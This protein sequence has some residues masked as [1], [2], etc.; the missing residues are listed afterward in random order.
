MDLLKKVSDAAGSAADSV[1]GSLGLN[2]LDESKVAAALTEALQVATDKAVALVSTPDG[3]LSNKR[4]RVPVPKEIEPVHSALSKLPGFD[5]V[6]EEFE[7]ALNRAAEVASKE[8]KDIFAPV[9]A[10]LSFEKAFEILN[11]ASHAATEFFEACT[12]KVL[13]GKFLPVVTE[14]MHDV[15]LVAVWE[16]IKEYVSKVPLLSMPDFDLN[17][18]V[19]T[20][21]L[22]GLF[23]VLGDKE[24]NIRKDPAARVTPLLQEVFKHAGK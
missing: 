22:D 24:E 21:A 1:A 23:V 20:R 5:S 12:R 6:M 9:I 3:F 10:A 13:Y 18:Y 15:G 17:D 2:D 16:K 19:T 11:G 4:I 14:R 8:A 7:V